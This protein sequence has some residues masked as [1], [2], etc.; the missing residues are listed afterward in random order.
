MV[1]SQCFDHADIQFGIA[2]QRII[3]FIKLPSHDTAMREEK[4]IHILHQALSWVDKAQIEWDATHHHIALQYLVSV[5]LA[6]LALQVFLHLMKRKWA[7]ID[8]R[9]NSGMQATLVLY[10]II[11]HP[12]SGGT[13]GNEHDVASASSPTIPEIFP[14]NKE[15][16]RFFTQISFKNIDLGKK[17]P[18]FL[19]SITISSLPIYQ[20]D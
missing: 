13:A 9:G 4:A 17:S 7:H 18:I 16:G 5:P 20:R 2:E 10:Q 19:V 6:M 1:L 3:E 11:H 8:A 12:G 15:N 14:K